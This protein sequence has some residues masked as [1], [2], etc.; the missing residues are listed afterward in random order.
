MEIPN[1][2]KG[3][4]KRL[5]IIPVILIIISLFFIPKI[6]LGIDFKGGTLITLKL[7]QDVDSNY[8]EQAFIDQG[9]T[10]QKVIVS[11]SAIGT[12]AEVELESDE[13][14]ANATKIHS[15]FSSLYYDVS[16]LKGW[17]LSVN[18]SSN[19]DQDKL[20]EYQEKYE[21]KLNEM[22]SEANML[23]A[24]AGNAENAS[25][26]TELVSLK[27]DVDKS[28]KQIKSVYQ[29]KIDSA[30]SQKLPYDSI[31]VDIV[32]PTLASHFIDKALFA[33]GLSLLFSITLAFVVFRNVASS[34]IVLS[35]AFADIVVSMGAMGLFGIPL[36]VA[37]FAALLMLV[38]L[39]LDTDM[40]LSMR[41]VKIQEDTPRNRAYSAL[42]TG[43]SMSV[44][45]F[46]AFLVL[47]LLGLFAGISTYYE[48]GAVACIGL[49]N[50]V[51]ATW[52]FNAVLVLW[53][54][55]KKM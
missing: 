3:N 4:Y 5:M 46:I 1:I 12:I 45:D 24:M 16:Q 14:I 35:G 15:E 31:S 51:I 38:G 7:T 29:H 54:V 28:F 10:P 53:Y 18:Q 6:Q 43:A 23:F 2:Y 8:V 32:S 42:K 40:L 37:S 48:I 19:P 22:E 11:K 34:M 44:T 27:R 13:K 21:T 9:I 30:V 47:F 50:D 41:V 39:S 25:D 36:T 49:I 20:A 17:I 33:V 55:E 52:G 26:Y